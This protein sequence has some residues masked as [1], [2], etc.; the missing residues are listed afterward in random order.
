MA[1]KIGEKIKALRKEKNISQES[2]AKVLGVTFQA[3]SKWETNITAPDVS[4]IPS[5]AS[6]F[7]VS[8]DELFDYNVFEN[9]KKI[10]SICRE[11]ARYRL[12]DP[13]RAEEILQEGLKQFPSNETMLTVLVY[14]LWNIPGRDSDLIDTCK[15]LIDCATIEGVRCDALRIL[16]EAY[17]RLGKYDQINSVL[18]QIPEF[19]FTKKECIARLTDGKNSLDAAHF[20]MNLSGS[21]LIEM[22]NIMAKQFASLGDDK[23]SAQCLRIANGI[24]DVFRNEDGKALEISGYEWLD[25]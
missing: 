8:I 17:H 20:Q 15:Q 12:D 25:F 24:L 18:A 23:K 3:V 13:I 19:Y 21:S 6:F 22:L 10:D 7:G 11:A 16:A 1:M 5:I 4:L 2:L 14:V 9:E